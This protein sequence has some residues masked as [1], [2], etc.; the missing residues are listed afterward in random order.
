MIRSYKVP[1][2]IPKNRYNDMFSLFSMVKDVYQE[3]VEWAY[4]N[5]TYRK[6]VAHKELYKQ[7]REKY[8]TLPCQFIQTTRDQSLE[9]VKR[10][11][12][13]TKKPQKR[14]YSSI[15]LVNG[16][17]ITYRRNGK[18]TFSTV[19]KRIKLNI[20]WHDYLDQ[21]LDNMKFKSGS[22]RYNQ[23]K[24]RFF[25]DLQFEI[26]PPDVKESKNVLGLD[27]GIH[28]LVAMS[29]GD[30]IN[31]KEIK[32]IKRKRQ[33]LRKCLQAKGTSS[34]KRHLR[35]LSGKEAR[36]STYVNHKVS[37]DI[38]NMNYDTFVLENLTHIRK[39]HKKYHKKLNRML[40]NW[41]FAQ[42]Q[43]FIAYKAESLGKR[44]VKVNPAYTSQ[45]CSSCGTIDKN[46]R[47][48][49]KY[50]CKNCN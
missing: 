15:R 14:K 41:S 30:I 22:I 3:H 19:G 5:K 39:A 40:S 17:T 11:K 4:Q 10:G 7:L 34:A 9:C 35:K 32:R 45:M 8:P 26:E 44:V 2:D 50:V 1:I 6:D 16:C 21:K 23:R 33:Y 24:K 43:S 38:V 36:F 27:L 25:L 29:N 37:K 12:F 28:N 20:N 13:K 47:F 42:L 48:K 49:S 46:A 31:S 18:I